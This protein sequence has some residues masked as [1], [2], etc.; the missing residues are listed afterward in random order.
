MTLLLLAKL[1]LQTDR[2]PAIPHPL[3]QPA[4]HPALHPTRPAVLGG[5]RGG[6]A[7]VHPAAGIT[8]SDWLDPAAQ[9]RVEVL[10]EHWEQTAVLTR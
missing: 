3:H 7:A 10:P 1:Q 9:C 2:L 4:R 5:H 6:R 8:H